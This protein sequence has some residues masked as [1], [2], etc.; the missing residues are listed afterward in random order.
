MKH[1]S[2]VW[3]S[4]GPTPLVMPG[5]DGGWALPRAPAPHPASP[6]PEWAARAVLALT[7]RA[8]GLTGWAARVRPPRAGGTLS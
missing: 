4:T 3:S 8:W 1:G 6:E 7:A 2:P 5:A